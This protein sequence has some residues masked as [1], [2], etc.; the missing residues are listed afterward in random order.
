VIDTLRADMLSSYGARAGQ[1]PSMDRLAHTG[2]QFSNARS[3]APWT[4]PGVGSILTSEYPSR[5]GLVERPLGQDVVIEDDS[6][7]EQINARLPESAKTIA[8]VLD[9]AGWLSGAFVNQQA[10]TGHGYEQGFTEWY[11]PAEGGQATLL[12]GGKKVNHDKWDKRSEQ[13]EADVA[14]VERFE[15]WLAQ[16]NGVPLFAYVHILSPHTPYAPPEEF[17]PKAAKP[18][19]KQLYI[20]DVRA[21][22]ALVGRVMDTVEQHIGLDSTL[23]IVTSDHG[24]E[25]WEHGGTGHGHTLFSE[26][27]NVPLLMAGPGLPVGSNVDAPVRTIDIGATLYDLLGLPNIGSGRSLVKVSQGEGGGSP[28][29]AEAML[30]GHTERSL[31]DGGF[32]L[33]HDYKDD[34]WQLYEVASDPKNKNDISANHPGQVAKMRKQLESLHGSLWQAC[35]TCDHQ[36]AESEENLEALRA[37]GYID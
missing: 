12:V 13:Y 31:Q 18:T 26:Q 2:V 5:L 11:Y 30:Y 16:N 15:A 23:V 29:Y 7:R 22:D 6:R 27:L 4:R 32:K 24:E 17:K 34:S 14:V 19:R 36:S 10:L 35:T 28:V 25:F 33:I 3:S 8:E 1:T 20:G 9:E 21:S 37:L